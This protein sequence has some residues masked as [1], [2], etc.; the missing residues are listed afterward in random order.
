M[1]VVMHE[2]H[3]NVMYDYDST[4]SL[5]FT[6][7]WLLGTGICSITMCHIYRHLSPSIFR[8]AVQVTDVLSWATS[9]CM[10]KFPDLKNCPKL[11]ASL[12]EVAK[13]YET[14]GSYVMLCDAMRLRAQAI[15]VARLIWEFT[16]ARQIFT[17]IHCR[18]FCLAPAD[19]DPF[20][21][22]AEAEDDMFFFRIQLPLATCIYQLAT[23]G[24]SPRSMSS[25]FDLRLNMVIYGW[26]L[27]HCP[28]VF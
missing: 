23:T 18:C 25:R 10:Q 3:R 24:T 8:T 12:G 13:P 7:T 20:N 6:I 14:H 17:D 19:V 5:K 2:W 1:S 4:G 27:A 16:L 21:M 28:M 15:D 22:D 26:Q 11:M 9:R